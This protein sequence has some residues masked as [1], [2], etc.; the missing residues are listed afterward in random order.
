VAR[1]R[2]L[3]FLAT[4]SGLLL[5]VAAWPDVPARAALFAALVL[6]CICTSLLS[7]RLLHR[8]LTSLRPPFVVEFITLLMFGP[9]AMTVVAVMGAGI[10]GFSEK[11]R[12]ESLLLRLVDVATVVVATLGAGFVY[13]SLGGD[14]S[15][16]FHW[17]WQALPT[18]AA[19]LAYCLV[20]S[21]SADLLLPRVT[22]TLR[23]GRGLM[24]A[25]RGCP[26]H[27]AGASVAVTLVEAIA[28]RAWGIL[29]V[30][31]LPLYFV[32][33]D[34]ASHARRRADEARR[35]S[36]MNALDRGL[37]LV[38]TSSRVTLWNPA[39]AR[40]VDCAPERALGR[41]VGG[42]LPALAETEL[43]RVVD[44]VVKQRVG[45]SLPRLVLNSR[46]G[47]GILHVD[48]LPEVG[49][50]LLLWHDVTEQ[51][52][53][54][55][56]LARDIDRLTLAAQ[57]ANDGLWSWDLRTGEFQVSPRWLSI[58]GLPPPAGALRSDIWL[59]RVHPDD[60]VSLKET[61]DAHLTGQI[62]PL[63][64]EHRLRHEDG[65]YRWCVCRGMAAG[66]HFGRV[67]RIA[68][69][70]TDI[71]EQAAE[72]ELARA[73]GSSDPLTG[74]NNRTIFMDR[75]G[76][77]LRDF[78]EHHESRFAVLYLDLDRFKI[79]NDSLGHLVGD[80]LLI[81]VSR[82]LEGCLRPGDALARLG[83]DEF[84]IL[85][86][87][88]GDDMQANV[89][90]MR[91][92]DA[93]G[94]P[95]SVGG[96]E[97]FTTV[98]IGIA[99]SRPEY[100]TP[101]DIMR[102]ADTAM[103]QA[104]SR[105]KARH[106]LF[107]ADMRAKAMDRLGLENDLRHAIADRGLEVHY[108]PIVSLDTGLC[109]GFESLVRWKRNGTFMSP[110][111]FVPI[112]E[113]LGLIDALGEWVLREACQQ[114]AGWRRRHPDAALD[115]ITVNVSA[116]QLMHQGFVRLVE[117]VVEQTKLKPCELR[118]EITETAL[119]DNPREAAKVVSGLREFG[120]K[121]YLDD[122]GTGYSS[123]SHLHKLP[124]DALKIDRSFVRSLMAHDRP[125]IVE[126]IL[127]LARTL[128]TG[129]VAEGVE[130]E[131]QAEELAR[132]GCRHA[133]GYYFSPPLPATDVEELLAGQR[134]LGRHA[135]HALEPWDDGAQMTA[136][137]S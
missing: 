65:S 113:E 81:A 79:V 111:D 89:V 91:I 15:A 114:F 97:V 18:G 64:H 68:G 56:S 66:R 8:D 5:G 126:S 74:L 130:S 62:K 134:P 30:A 84:V 32:W 105:G 40:L 127:A 42:A 75:L 116:R 22:G 125:A 26:V 76:R 95:F 13:V 39:L 23:V 70:L 86:D 54:S 112:A 52:R 121:I 6:A 99:F 14:T 36:A 4:A 87:R 45:R 47:V 101:D 71:T 82:R 35:L 69:S 58:L 83:G 120:V 104:K 60:V 50:A 31:A 33:R 19:V 63:E 27:V 7:P 37:A 21:V 51:A 103:Y 61:L 117:Q 24:H 85:L 17:P 73:A 123:L 94:A 20:L 88:L 137:V 80:E 34:H 57:A 93:L 10:R 118:L 44:D 2:V 16:P 96:R 119:M 41:T 9:H 132:L 128:D 107:D 102:D 106:E 78:H 29:P 53:A 124:V 110:G 129:V 77:A 38:D 59:D 1:V 46:S 49:G 98:S 100:V 122:F 108:Q 12:V 131:E 67:D 109:A 115:C 72:R 90:A 28:Y 48:V 43:P 136:S 3:A 55:Q 11:A 92:Q 25:L 133:Q 135:G